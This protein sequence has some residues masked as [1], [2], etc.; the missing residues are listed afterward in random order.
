MG[1]RLTGTYERHEPVRVVATPSRGTYEPVIA[2]LDAR[3]ARISLSF[4]RPTSL[5]VG[6]T[7]LRL[8][9]EARAMWFRPVDAAPPDHP[10]TVRLF[11]DVALERPI[12]RHRVMSRTTLAVVDAS[13]PVV[14]PQE[15]V[16]LGGPVSGP[17]YGYHALV[18]EV[19]GSLH[20][21]WRLPAPSV[22]IPLGRFGEAPARM[23][24]APFA[25]V[26]FLARTPGARPAGWYP[27]L[28]AGALLF[29]DALRLDVGRGLRDG[30]WT[31]G[32]DL[33]PELWRVL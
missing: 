24:L 26:V 10:R 6:G 29:F 33:T 15:L 31:F 9:G 2:A 20:L 32:V 21:E 3:A 27:S 19:G 23:T 16:Y 30:T 28:G 17:G 4:D 5:F 22:A 11:V 14:P 8:R 13:S 7:E 12:G 25:H 1:W 18:G